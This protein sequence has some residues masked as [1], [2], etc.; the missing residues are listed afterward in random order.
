MAK[1]GELPAATLTEHYAGDQKKGGGRLSET[2]ELAGGI[3]ERRDL[4]IDT[5]HDVNKDDVWWDAHIEKPSDLE[6]FALP[7]TSFSIAHVIGP[8]GQTRSKEHPWGDEADE[9]VKIGNAVAR[10]TI[11]RMLQVMARGGA[12]LVENPLLSFFWWLP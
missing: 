8:L 10:I 1:M 2:W 6:S 4:L 3:A 11:R 5:S 9:S 7:C 12:I